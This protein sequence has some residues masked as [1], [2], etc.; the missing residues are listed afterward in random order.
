MDLK[1]ESVSP[2]DQS[3][4]YYYRSF[5]IKFKQDMDTST[6]NSQNILAF[7]DKNSTEINC[8]YN[9]KSRELQV[10]IKLDTKQSGVARNT[11]TI[12][13]LLTKNIKK[14]DGKFIDNDYVY[15]IANNE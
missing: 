13:V 6:L 10:D 9:A 2:S 8:N 12:Y 5:V 11:A 15:S 4:G 14:A 3:K 7:V 1:N